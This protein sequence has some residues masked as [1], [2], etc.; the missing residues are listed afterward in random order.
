MSSLQ[1][2]RAIKFMSVMA[3]II[4]LGVLI[5]GAIKQSAEDKAA[6][7]YGVDSTEVTENFTE[8]RGD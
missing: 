8:E 3:M 6:A 2:Y 7:N 4:M 5:F 1:R